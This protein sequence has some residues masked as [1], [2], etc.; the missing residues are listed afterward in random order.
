MNIIHFAGKVLVADEKQRIMQEFIVHVTVNLA[1]IY[2]V[3]NETEKKY[4]I[5]LTNKLCGWE[6]SEETYNNA[7]NQLKKL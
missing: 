6:V 5:E 4:W 2:L 1:D 3:Y 7:L